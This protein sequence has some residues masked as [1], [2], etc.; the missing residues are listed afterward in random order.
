MPF[1]TVM[2]EIIDSV[3]GIS[4]YTMGQNKI[5]IIWYS[6]DVVLIANNED[7]LKRQIH[8]VVAGVK[9]FIQRKKQMS[10]NGKRFNKVQITVRRDCK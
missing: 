10:N 2:D 5:N 7:N 1:N 8:K 4:G 9:D 3:K 6:D